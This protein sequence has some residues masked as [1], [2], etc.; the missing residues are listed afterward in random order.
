MGV[1]MEYKA[2]VMPRG[3]TL[4]A[5]DIH[6]EIELEAITG[7]ACIIEYEGDAPRAIACRRFETIGPN[8]YVGAI[9]SVARGYRQFR[10]DRITTVSDV[11]SGETLGAGEYFR[12]FQIERTRDVADT[13][14]L[15]RARHTHLLAGLNVLA[16]MAHCDGEWHPVEAEMIE[17]FVCAL[18]LRKEWDGDPPLDKIVAHARRLAPDASVFDAA[19]R[20]FIRSSTSGHLLRSYIAKVV[21]ADGRITDEEHLWV[22]HFDDICQEY[23][24]AERAKA[25]MGLS[26]ELKA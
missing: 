12:R 8:H 17:K 24:N 16:F 26:L 15:T 14:G 2:T 25:R 20:N 5:G 18:W 9:C 1:R 4:P 23:G 3:G 13:W 21:A 22:T 19:L 11:L 6:E 10:C 7:F